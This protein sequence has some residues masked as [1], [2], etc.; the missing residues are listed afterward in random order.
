[1]KKTI[2]L[3]SMLLGAFLFGQHK[4]LNLPKLDQ[5]DVASTVSTMDAKV[6]AEV[7]YD[8]HHFLIDT[9]GF[10]TIEV[11]KRVKIYDKTKAEEFLNV[12]IP[13]KIKGGDRE[14]V[15]GLKA[16]TYNLENGKVAATTVDKESRIKSNET[17]NVDILKF[18]FAN[19]KNGSV[20]EYK[21]KLSTPF[22]Y[23]IPRVMVESAVPVRY[24]EYVFD[25]PIYL[26]YSINYQGSLAP[27][28]RDVSQKDMY[29]GDYKTVRF[30][31]E[32]VKAYKDEKYVYNIDNYRTAI[33]A[34]LASTNFPI[35]SKMGSISGGF[36]SYTVTW[37]DLRKTILN[38]DDFGVEYG[39]MGAVKD[40]LPAEIKS[41]ANEKERADAILKYV[42]K[43]YTWNK[44]VT[45]WS[46]DGIRNLISKKIGNS[47]EIN[48]LLTMLMKSAGLK[49]NPAIMPTKKRGFL[50]FNAPSLT[51]INYVLTTVEIGGK[52]TLYDATSKYSAANVLPSR[53]YNYFAYL[54]RDKEGVQI[55]VLPD[56]KSSTIQVANARFN[57]DG[58]ISGD[59]S[60]TDA[61][62]YALTSSEAYN[63]DADQYFKD[64]KEN[65]KFPIE[66]MKGEQ[67][68]NGTF[69]TKFNFN[70]D[71]FVDGVGGK[72]VFNPL[73]FLF[74]KNHDFDQ[75]DARRSPIE[76]LSGYDRIKKVTV[77]LPDGYT[78]EN[79]PK[80]KKFR[81]EDSSVV[82]SYVIKQD[83]N[84]LTVESTTS[85]EDSIYP[86]AYYPVFKQ[87][88]DNITNMEAQVVTV[89][90][91]K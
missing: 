18:A 11:I 57:V 84:K 15:S 10:M 54:I 82:Y 37:E 88:F 91:K 67:M 79:L 49:A 40:I 24:F 27:T 28:F 30:A 58:T 17:K 39:K 46:E 6:P 44:K 14:S 74:R 32:N 20:L 34:E 60:D 23:A 83:G 41:I 33:R 7:L 76:M 90:K 36:K 89:V 59:F 63:K 35:T 38:E 26:G 53:A 42:Q 64:Y 75:E 65:Y 62:L 50:N 87:V 8:S 86:E 12:E 51:Q 3:T 73:L 81:S 45:G 72:F 55:N 19:V 78:F 25:M 4:F 66:N 9:N 1:M 52:L 16:T 80:S 13:L 47:A 68:E 77:E 31:Y 85:V 61:V 70:S 29:G 69:V 48:L 43:N 71:N 5:A 22:Y 2:L 21:Y 56:G